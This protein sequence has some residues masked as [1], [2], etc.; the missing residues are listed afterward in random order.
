MESS[1]TIASAGIGGRLNDHV[2]LTRVPLYEHSLRALR[3]TLHRLSSTS[4]LALT[5]FKRLRTKDPL[6]G[7][8]TQ[9]D[10]DGLILAQ[11]TPIVVFTHGVP[12]GILIAHV[13]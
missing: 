12:C 7:E 10:C 1:E 2:W 4:L 8:R 5:C 9:G 3:R 13:D 6:L 11:L